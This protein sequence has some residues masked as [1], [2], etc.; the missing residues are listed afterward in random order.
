MD[1]YGPGRIGL[2]RSGPN[3][4][5]NLMKLSFV[6]NLPPSDYKLEREFSQI[7]GEQNP[8]S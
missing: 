6:L 3:M 8:D 4:K 7:E 1:G 5:L 2:A